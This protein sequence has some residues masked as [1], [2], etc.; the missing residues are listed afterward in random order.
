MCR[1]N[2]LECFIFG[3]FVA[4][5]KKVLEIAIPGSYLCIAA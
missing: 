1:F 5:H 3:D 2:A 4:V